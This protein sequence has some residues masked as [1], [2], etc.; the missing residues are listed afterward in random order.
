MPA[1]PLRWA[2]Q[3]FACLSLATGIAG[4]FIPGLPTTVFVLMAGWPRRAARSACTPGCGAIACSAP[5]CATGTGRLREPA[6]QM[7]RQRHDEPVRRHT[8]VDTP[9]RLGAG[10]GAD[11]HGLRAGVAVVSG[12]NREI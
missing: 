8:A 7:E 4:I 11:L 3:L 9:A 12:P 6:R 10:R 2:L 1:A 5:C